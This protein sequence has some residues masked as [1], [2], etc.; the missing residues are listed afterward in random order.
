LE[1]SNLPATQKF[2]QAQSK[3]KQTMIFDYDHQGIIMTDGVP[4]GIS[5]TAAYYRHWM[6]KFR[7]KMPKNRPDLLGDFCTT[8]H[9]RTWGR[10]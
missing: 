8:M 5:V 6:Q 10:L 1:K 9:A 2:R 7:R 3:V 4:F